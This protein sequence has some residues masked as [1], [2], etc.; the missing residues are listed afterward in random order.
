MLLPRVACCF[1]DFWRKA[2]C[3]HSAVNLLRQQD[4]ALAFSYEDLN[5]HD[6]LRHDS[7]LQPMVDQDVDMTI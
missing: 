5:D 3:I 6:T 1:S 2:S 7:T 4:Y